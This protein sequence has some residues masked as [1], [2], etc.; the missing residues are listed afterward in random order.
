MVQV[1]LRGGQVTVDV[2]AEHHVTWDYDSPRGPGRV[3][4]NCSVADATVTLDG[5]RAWQVLGTVAVEHG[6]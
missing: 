1:P 3:V 5:G 4:R 2:R 6:A